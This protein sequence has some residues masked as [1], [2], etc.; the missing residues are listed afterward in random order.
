MQ[1]VKQYIA[2]QMSI[3]LIF[4]SFLQALPLT[5]DGTTNTTLETSRNGIPI[6]NIANPNSKGLSHNKYR[7]FNVNSEGLILN[8]SISNP[9][10][11]LD[12][13]IYGNPN[14]TN[15][16]SVILNEVT[17]TSRTNLNGYT[18]I[19][20]RT[21][22][23]VIANPNGLTINDAGFINTN[24]VTLSS[25][26]PNIINSLIDSY[27]ISNSDIII[28]GSGLNAN[29]IN[30]DIY[31]A[32]LQLNAFIHAKQLNINLKSEAN[33]GVLLDSS[34]LGGMYANAI[35]LVGT[36]N[37]LGVNLPS[38]V[39][40]TSGD[41]TITND[42]MIV[43]EDLSA[44]NNINIVSNNGDIQLNGNS[45][46][47]NNTNLEAV[48]IT[49]EAIVT[50]ANNTTIT[51]TLLTNNDIIQSGVESNNSLN[52]TGNININTANINNTDANIT[53]SNN[54]NIT[55][56]TIN[57]TNSTIIANNDLTLNL[58]SLDNT[59]NSTIKANNDLI[60]NILNDILNNSNITALNNLTVNASSIMNNGLFNSGNDLTITSSNLTNN[61]T[62]FSKND[63]FLYTENNLTNNIN[64][65]ILAINNLTLSSNSDND[66]TNLIQNLSANIQTV[67]G[68]INIWARDF[69]NTSNDAE[70][71]L[72]T[73][74]N[75]SINLYMYGKYDGTIRILTGVNP[76]NGDET[77]ETR[78]VLRH[79][80]DYYIN[81]FGFEIRNGA[82]NLPY[83]HR[84]ERSRKITVT[85]KEERFVSGPSNVAT[86]TSGNDLNLNVTN[87]RNYLG[88]I[89]ANNN[90]NFL[91]SSGI[92]DN[93][94]MN[95]Y[96][97]YVRTGKYR[98]CYK[99]CH[100]FWHDPD[101]TWAN[102]PTSTSKTIIGAVHSTIQAGGNITGDINT[103]N[104]GDLRENSIPSATSTSLL[105]EQSNND[106]NNNQFKSIILPTN[107]NGLFITSKDP[108]ASYLVE[109]NPE[110]TLYKNFI[111]SDYLMQHV[112]FSPDITTTRLG[113]AFY[114]QTLISQS[115]FAQTGRAYL[116]SSISNN[117][118]QYEYLMNNAISAQ[119]DLELT[120]GISLSQEQIN[121][122]TNDIVWLE[123]QTV[124][125]IEVLVPVVYIA[126][127]DNYNISG[128]QIIA[129]KDIALKVDNLIN[130]GT[131]SANNSIAI[132]ATNSIKNTSGNIKAVNN[133]NLT[134]TNDI[135]NTSGNIKASSVDITST[136]GDIINQR[137]SKAV[138]YS[139]GGNKDKSTLI[140][141]AGSIT[142][143]SQP[144]NLNAQ[145][146]SVQVIAS[147]LDSQNTINI[148]ANEF[149]A[150]TVQNKKDF[151]AGDSNN[152]IKENSTTH[153]G[154]NINSNNLNID[155][156]NATTLK[157]A[158]VNVNE[159]IDINA[160][161]VNILAVQDNSFRQTKT[162]KKGFL[163]SESTTTTDYTLT[164]K[165][166]TLNSDGQ[167]NIN[168]RNNV[169]MQSA[170]ID[171]SNGAS[172]QSENGSVNVLALQD[173][174]IH[175]VKK[176]KSGFSLDVSSDGVSFMKKT[177]DEIRTE[178]YLSKGTLLSSSSSFNIKAKENIILQDINMQVEDDISLEATDV[179]ILHGVNK[180][181]NSQ[182]HESMQVGANINDDGA[183]LIAE[184]KKDTS[185]TTATNVQ[186]SIINAG[187]K[188]NIKASNDVNIVSTNI[189]ATD[190][191][192]LE[193]ENV[194]IKEA[195]NTTSTKTTSESIKGEATI[196]VKN[197]YVEAAKAAIA[198]KDA[199]K[200]LKDIKDKYDDYKKDL[201]N[202]ISK[203]TKLKADF[204]NGKI[205]IEQIDIDEFGDLID[206]LKDDKAFYLAA[207][208]GAT[209][210]LASKTTAL[211]A[212]TAKA[213]SSSGTYGM[214]ASLE[215]KGTL[216]KKSSTSNSSTSVASNINTNNFVIKANN[217]ALI[218]GSNI[219]ATYGDIDAKSIDI[220]ASK[221][222]SNS[223]S[224]DETIE[225]TYSIGTSG[226][227]SLEGS[228]S[229][230][231]NESG[232]TTYNNSNLNF[233]NLNLTSQED[234]TIKG[235]SINAKN[236]LNVE[237]GGSLDIQSV[238]NVNSSSSQSASVS[239]SG[240]FSASKSKSKEKTTLLTSLNARSVNI[241]VN[242]NT[243]L[244]G[245]LISSSNDDL[246]INTN[247]LTTSNLSN[248]SS[249]R[250]INLGGSSGSTV[251]GNLALG[252]SNS[253]SKT[254]STI[255]NGDI[256]I[257]NGSK[258]LS[259]LNRNKD[260]INLDLYDVKSDVAVSAQ[261][262][263]RML[264][265]EGR[266]D[267][268][269]ELKQSKVGFYDVAKD[270]MTKDSVSILDAFT[271]QGNK[272][273]F[274]NGM[275]QAMQ[276][277]ENRNKL[278]NPN[279]TQQQKNTIM[280]EIAT[281]VANELGITPST[282]STISTN[283]QTQDG[284]EIKGGYHEDSGDIVLNDKNINSTSD[285]ISTLGHELGH[286][287][288]GDRTTNMA[289]EYSNIM[290]EGLLDYATFGMNNY[291][292]GK[293]LASTNNHIGLSPL[294]DTSKARSV[295]EERSGNGEVEYKREQVSRGVVF[296]QSLADHKMEV[297][298]R[299][300]PD[301][302]TKEQKEKYGEPIK[303]GED[304]YG[305]VTEAL[306][307]DGKLIPT[308]NDQTSVNAYKN[309]ET[310][311]HNSNDDDYKKEDK[312]LENHNNNK[313]LPLNEQKDY[314]S[315]SSTLTCAILGS[316]SDN[317]YNSNTYADDLSVNA[318]YRKNKDNSDS[319]FV[320]IPGSREHLKNVHKKQNEDAKT[321]TTLA[322]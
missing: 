224:K 72:H 34:T 89:S 231:T 318:D 159:N 320:N 198:V 200:A 154:S 32:H 298:T 175:D 66:K 63:M 27:G 39:L 304:K 217:K 108:L 138:D 67:D 205:G 314:P 19:A 259:K 295:F 281:S 45:S 90:I 124:N 309:G 153:I 301:K 44:S 192:E 227:G 79:D 115:I 195:K 312:L 85:I 123:Q 25:S 210:S 20:G 149:I 65:N 169:T 61:T 264:S 306:N 273:D 316:C 174:K 302:F 170:N 258:D 113:D 145:N 81:N 58:D 53:A 197:E 8:N 270:I 182:S 254:L 116:D 15:E 229:S 274:F 82:I 242:N 133:L 215:L 144:L 260:D 125:G 10:T 128:G 142:S 184:I 199:T 266:E 95:L 103:V 243:N 13:Y 228:A 193:G 269:K 299:E 296:N 261:V 5:P 232:S 222:T 321:E 22:D 51:G 56:N 49:N 277:E 147:N 160:S 21:A 86:L 130:S 136:S 180:H 245:A 255:T 146:G 196:K 26:T 76:E 117:N 284:K 16:A 132:D 119:Q 104:N 291:G 46:S 71:S 177:K 120:P 155:T 263:T 282:V 55:S 50:S 100:S 127:I 6:V 139:S 257:A 114:E 236:N 204:K 283:Q 276:N 143:T 18:E 225:V 48:N 208:A 219:D 60:L 43:L 230:A 141:E 80:N 64:S 171:A 313:N 140:G 37:G 176:V 278:A 14:L 172:I 322:P 178:D 52:T 168:A 315:N 237:V 24:N 122:L 300:S 238:Q 267:I 289:E 38:E 157:G 105:Q 96:K 2:I 240:S 162:T 167:I 87:T 68:D 77:Y 126:N 78:P 152:Y 97:Q 189:N 212:Q 173:V 110:F 165:G 11:Q 317:F 293:T 4:T 220:L 57:T 70:V 31:T 253:K 28:E 287:V 17:S 98:Y 41:I 106:L 156:T 307:K 94:G 265:K 150:T 246:T 74:P 233:E 3:S 188:L 9:T 131:L 40:A 129:N 247:T 121:N 1:L 134:A 203:L 181:I 42:G 251:S 209:A 190:A 271:H 107:N 93:T 290:G 183:S 30:L 35:T 12:G 202:Q 73:V 91:D 118:D 214:S 288:A 279:L 29:D 311:L 179:S 54:I 268:A 285:A 84:E 83:L 305:Y 248:S 213:A 319:P 109:T 221:D 191:V 164:N 272:V 239:T 99:E 294:T 23:L 137:Y 280:Q 187:G 262:D 163:S 223:S 211:I 297:I 206:D 185:V 244:R 252:S 303:L 201:S 148:D 75:H 308:T 218:Q 135:I 7:E 36:S 186:Q 166:T 234:T 151:F 226:A 275:Q 92:V 88:K 33:T 111:S 59:E 286:S 292:N 249:S 62:L 102:L 161:A 158:N 69:N 256:N 216:N 207:V 47:L 101:Y 235:V 112:E 194:S 241:D 250:N 310:T